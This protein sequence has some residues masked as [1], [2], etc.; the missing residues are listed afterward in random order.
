MAA[1]LEDEHTLLQTV[2]ARLSPRVVKGTRI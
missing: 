1:S 2:N